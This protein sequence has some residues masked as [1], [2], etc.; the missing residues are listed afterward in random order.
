VRSGDKEEVMESLGISKEA[1]NERYLGMPIHVGKSRTKTFRHIKDRVWKLIQG[2]MEKLLSRA[3]KEILIK[4]V[5]QAIPT[6]TMS[7]FDLTKTIC[8]EISTSICKYWWSQQDKTNK[9]HW[10]SWEKLTKPKAEGGLGL[11]EIYAF[12]LAMLA[13]QGWRI[14]QNPDSLCA[15]V[16]GAKY[17][18]DGNCL[19]ATASAGMSYTWRSILKGLEVLKKGLI[20]RVGDGSSIKIWEDPWIPRGISRLP[21]TPKNNMLKMVSDL[22][23][24]ITGQWDE[25][26]IRDNFNDADSAC[27]LA[28]PTNNDVDDRPAWHFDSK[29]LF[30]VKSAYWVEIMHRNLNGPR[31]IASVSDAGAKGFPWMKIWMMSVPNKIKHFIWRLAHNTTPFC[32]NLRR[33]GMDISP[34]C[35]V[36]RA[37]HEDGG[38]SLFKCKR[39]KEIWRLCGLEEERI[40]LMR[41]IT[42]LE[43]VE[44]MLS[45]SAEKSATIATLLWCWWCERNSVREGKCGRTSE[46]LAWTVKIQADEFLK[47]KEVAPKTNTE[48][49]LKRWVAPDEDWIK[50]NIDGSFKPNELSG[51]WGAVFRDADG[52][53]IACSA[54]FIPNLQNALQAEV[55]AAEHALKIAQ[56]FGMGNVCLETDAL[57]LKN[58]L[59]DNRVDLSCVGIV[60]ERIK[61]YACCNFSA[62]KILY[63]PRT[64]NQVAHALA[65]KGAMMAGEAEFVTDG[66]APFV[67]DLVASDLALPTV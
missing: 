26:L 21:A 34:L 65:A 42:A 37:H 33:K 8:D 46:D 43:T 11:R 19:N 53:V 44:A 27:I 45:F 12:N 14:L 22:I 3:G 40:V 51:G 52:D 20:W 58:A 28:I 64:C 30:S 13:R 7:C 62:V 39:V 48:G 36:C 61:A 32:I 63:C 54:G 35:P 17:F 25:V 4:A 49:L 60:I 1:L 31:G 6:F 10:L 47:L 66:L 9:I 56:A 2:W 24:P 16:L 55:L 41:K 5:A 59:E 15:Q 23:S 50:V 57:L 67:T 29:G 38:H 18:P